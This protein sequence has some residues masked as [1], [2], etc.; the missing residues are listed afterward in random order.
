M[1]W[2][3][4]DMLPSN[5]GERRFLPFSISVCGQIR[6]SGELI[7]MGWRRKTFIFSEKVVNNLSQQHCLNFLHPNLYVFGS[8]IRLITRVQK[9]VLLKSQV[10]I[11]PTHLTEK[12]LSWKNCSKEPKEFRLT[13]KTW[14]IPITNKPLKNVHAM[15]TNL[16]SG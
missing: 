4:R 6:V 8:N 15:T 12:L 7:N 14:T 13:E 3:G 16:L 11:S 5:G 9:N 2:S 1:I 10:N